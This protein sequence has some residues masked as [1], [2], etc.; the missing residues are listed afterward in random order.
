LSHFR[1]QSGEDTPAISMSFL[2]SVYSRIAYWMGY[3][4]KRERWE[5]M[6]VSKSLYSGLTNN[7][8]IPG[9]EGFRTSQNLQIT[10]YKA[11]RLF[12]LL[13]EST[14]NRAA[15]RVLKEVADENSVH[16]KESLILL[17]ELVCDTEKFYNHSTT[18]TED[19]NNK[20]MKSG[21]L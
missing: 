9:V 13:A 12:M 18:K 2:T 4:K 5:I 3:C 19:I 14:N 15:I 7:R 17:H 8:K 21:F 16:V 10:E 20:K 6:S 1:K 11:T